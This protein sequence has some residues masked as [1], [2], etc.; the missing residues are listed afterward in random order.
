MIWI[1]FLLK[2]R[3]VSWEK[4]FIEYSTIFGVT[5]NLSHSKA[6][7]FEWK[8]A[9]NLGERVPQFRERWRVHSFLSKNDITLSECVHRFKE[10][11]LRCSCL[12]R[13]RM[14]S[15]FDERLSDRSKIERSNT[16]SIGLWNTSERFLSGYRK[17]Q[18]AFY[19]NIERFL[20]RKKA[21][22]NNI[23]RQ[24]M[25]SSRLGNILLLDERIH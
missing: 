22:C 12:E 18:N 8:L 4:Q 11:I 14:R 10:P 3:F 15:H 21:F 6:G 1:F 25:D 23:E 9:L 2:I 13:Q 5:F 17:A 7:N 20:N 16:Y 24:R 19:L